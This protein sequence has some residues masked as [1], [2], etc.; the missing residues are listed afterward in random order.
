LLPY[1]AAYFALRAS[2]LS[3]SAASK[4]LADGV[5]NKPYSVASVRGTNGGSRYAMPL[6]IKPER[7]Q[8]SENSLNSPSKQSCDVL[9]D[10]DTGSY[11]ANDS[12]ELGPQAGAFAFDASSLAGVANVLT[13][14]PAADDI[15]SDSIGSQS[16][17]GNC[18]D[19][20]I[21]RDCRPVFREHGAR[22]GVDL[23]EGDSLHSRPLEP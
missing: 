17:S 11:I 23:A 3:V 5:G 10:D 4:P 19:V 18:S 12:G 2:N 16:I 13:R 1:F 21:A 9:H 14:E 20:V 22:V 8:V 15:D 6:R 7:G